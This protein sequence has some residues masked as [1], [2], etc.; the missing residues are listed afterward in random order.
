MGRVA[1]PR[2]AQGERVDG[3][4]PAR[5]R[6]SRGQFGTLW[7]GDSGSPW[8]DQAAGRL[9][10]WSY[11]TPVGGGGAGARDRRAGVDAL[12]FR[13]LGRP[14]SAGDFVLAPS[15]RG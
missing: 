5:D 14:V 15:R 7:A 1:R 6:V 10:L 13:P 4:D 8:R 3:D 12:A 11:T 2:P 9:R